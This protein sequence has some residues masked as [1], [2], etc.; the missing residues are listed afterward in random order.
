MMVM[1]TSRL[2]VHVC[3]ARLESR[4]VV[5][6]LAYWNESDMPAPVVVQVVDDSGT[7][8]PYCLTIHRGLNFEQELAPVARL[9]STTIKETPLPEKAFDDGP[10]RFSTARLNVLETKNAQHQEYDVFLAFE[11]GVA[12]ANVTG[13]TALD[14]RYIEWTELSERARRKGLTEELCRGLMSRLGTPLAGQGST[15]EGKR[16]ISRMKEL[17]IID[18]SR[19]PTDAD[20]HL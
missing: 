3:P 15:P 18:N 17:G 10:T 9:V 2:V 12:P 5:L 11:S 1:E 13:V 7:Y 6:L 14:G 8:P 4:G 19:L 16:F 20:P